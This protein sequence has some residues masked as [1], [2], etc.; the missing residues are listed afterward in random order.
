MYTYIWRTPT[1]AQN[2]DQWSAAPAFGRRVHVGAV[3]EQR[4]HHRRVAFERGAMERRV[5]AVQRARAHT[6]Q[7][8]PSAPCEWERACA[9]SRAR[10]RVY[11]SA[12][13]RVS[14]YLAPSE[15]VCVF[16]YARA[17]GRV[18]AC[19]ERYEVSFAERVCARARL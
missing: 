14:A 7:R 18:R 6:P 13:V 3:R 11:A 15:R 5:P 17:C 8:A 19:A 12:V 1:V 4:R 16:V 10:M 9:R 2:S